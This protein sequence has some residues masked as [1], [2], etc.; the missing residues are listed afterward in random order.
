M[1]PK[2][3][4]VLTTNGWIPFSQLNGD[5][6]VYTMTEDM[7]Y[8]TTSKFDSIIESNEKVLKIKNRNTN[9][10]TYSTENSN[11]ILSSTLEF[12]SCSVSP[13][14]NVYNNYT[15]T[16]MYFLAHCPNMMLDYD[17]MF[18]S[19]IRKG[20]K[21]RNTGKKYQ[22][23]SKS[24]SRDYLR[25]WASEHKGLFATDDKMISELQ[26]IALHAGYTS[27]VNRE[28][29]LGLKL[30]LIDANQRITD[31]EP[32]NDEISLHECVSLMYNSN[33]LSVVCRT[34]NGHV[35]ISN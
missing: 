29:S 17:L 10:R 34:Q 15:R 16:P 6:A 3:F 21:D 31:I 23:L 12:N 1:I 20:A 18:N 24:L 27:M 9:V 26:I 28:S 35:F 7:K 4:S 2:I 30:E 5:E 25:Y 8:L 14:F 13:M 32:L 19:D 33:V 22:N 11:V